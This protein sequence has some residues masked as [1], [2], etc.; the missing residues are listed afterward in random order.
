MSKP[1]WVGAVCHCGHI[2]VLAHSNRRL[3]GPRRKYASEMSPWKDKDKEALSIGHYEQCVGG[4]GAKEG[5]KAQLLCMD[6]GA[7]SISVSCRV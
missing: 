7:E 4:R 6:S 5:Q 3:F 2:V 1:V